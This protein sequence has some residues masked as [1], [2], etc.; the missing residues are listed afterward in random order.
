MKSQAIKELE[1]L[2]IIFKARYIL[3]GAIEWNELQD[4]EKHLE[5][6]MEMLRGED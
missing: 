2:Q 3:G 1:R 6:V 4:C 5:R